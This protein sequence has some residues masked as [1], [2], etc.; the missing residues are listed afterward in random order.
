MALARKRQSRSVLSIV[1]SIWVTLW[2]HRTKRIMIQWYEII[3]FLHFS[4]RPLTSR[5][6]DLL[7]IELAVVV[8]IVPVLI[9]NPKMQSRFGILTS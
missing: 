4:H 3:A 8:T 9:R 6:H 1:V 7:S 2:A 5:R